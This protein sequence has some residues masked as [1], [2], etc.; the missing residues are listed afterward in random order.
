VLRA[1]L[2]SAAI[3]VPLVVAGVLLLPTPVFALSLAAVLL[4]ASWEWSRLIPLSGAP[5]RLGYLLGITLLLWLLWQSGPAQ[6]MKPVLLAAF[7]WWL[8]VLFWLSRPEICAAATRPNALF[9]GMAGVLAMVPAW[10]ALT[11]L[12][13]NHTGGPWLILILLF[14]IWLADSGA[15]FAG[16]RWGHKRLAPAISPGKTWEGVYGGL[17]ASL[18]FAA[19]AGWF[20]S[21]SVSWS[22]AFLMVSLLVVLFSIAGDLLESLMK[23]HSGVKDSGT[24]IPGHGGLLDR[25][26]SL[27]A[28]APLFL[29]GL[30][31]LGL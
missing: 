9:K 23:R 24:V 29:L 15:Y 16:R 12:H 14:M 27:L 28:A 31:W 21:R 8:W 17:L 7:S 22:L 5:A 20:Y 1:R 19:V 10:L 18:V 30:H 3:I 2:I 25:I 11:V 6:Y 26:D 4:P 13:G